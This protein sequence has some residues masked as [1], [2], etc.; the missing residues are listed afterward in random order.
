MTVL[1]F[2][3][4]S[5]ILI[6]SILFALL[7][8]RTEP[9][10]DTCDERVMKSSIM[11]AVLLGLF[12]IMPFLILIILY[13]V[14]V[15]YIRHSNSYITSLMGQGPTPSIHGNTAPANSPVCYILID[16]MF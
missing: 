6:V 8:D 14:V 7:L 13:A 15:K 10:I 12:F 3:W 4:L 16:V 9:I 2:I 11:R 5:C 1:S